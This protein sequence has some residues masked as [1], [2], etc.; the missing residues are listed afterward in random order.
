MSELNALALHDILL[1][2]AD[3]L[4]QAQQQLRDMAPYD[5]YGR[6]NTIYQLPYLDFQLQVTTEFEKSPVVVPGTSPLSAINRSMLKF[7]PITAGSAPGNNSSKIESTISGRFVAV[8]PNEG[9]PQVILKCTN[10]IPELVTEGVNSFYK[11]DIE[12]HLY[13]VNNEN[14][15]NA[16]VEFNFDAVGSK[17]INGT[18]ITQTPTFDISEGITDTDGKLKSTVKVLSNYYLSGLYFLFLIN[19]GNIYDSIS[20]SKT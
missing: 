2:I 11:F 5:E 14:I 1:S 4:N 18:E 7:R 17:S 15:N 8:I 20:I 12:A 9:L 6:P 19:S 13:N 10:T 16:T 3:S